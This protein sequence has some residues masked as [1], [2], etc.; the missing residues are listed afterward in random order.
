M[1]DLKIHKYT[2][3][4]C[5]RFFGGEGFVQNLFLSETTY[6]GIFVVLSKIESF[7]SP[8]WVEP[9]NIPD[10]SK[11]GLGPFS[12]TDSGHELSYF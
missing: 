5:W 7:E 8:G 2:K 10:N 9:E 6:T 4:D 11:F 12:D 1:C 3:K